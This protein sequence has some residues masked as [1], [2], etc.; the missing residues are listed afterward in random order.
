RPFMPGI[1]PSLQPEQRRAVQVLTTDGP[2]DHL[3]TTQAADLPG[4]SL[5]PSIAFPYSRVQ[6]IRR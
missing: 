1:L 4:I 6:G 5:G 3:T 2:P